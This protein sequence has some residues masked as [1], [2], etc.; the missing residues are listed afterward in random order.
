M[1]KNEL[2]PKIQEDDET[3]EE[4]DDIEVIECPGIDGTK[5]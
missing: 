2:L 3:K 1:E 4:E 5:Q